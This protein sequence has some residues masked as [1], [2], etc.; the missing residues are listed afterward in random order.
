MTKI[1]NIKNEVLIRVYIVG[2]MIALC[3]LII[4]GQ[5]VKIQFMEGEKWRKQRESTMIEEKTVEAEQGNIF[6]DD[7]SIL[8]TS[9]PFFD[10]RFDPTVASDELFF[11][12]V[13][14]LAH[15]LAR[16][17]NN[18]TEGGWQDYLI[19][20]R[21]A[22]KKYLEIL[23]K[24]SYS[25][26]EK[27]K[28]FPIFN[29][30]RYQGGFIT[31]ERFRRHKPFRPLGNRTLG[32]VRK[33]KKK[34]DKDIKVG[35]EGYFENYLAGESGKRLMYKLSGKDNWMPVDDLTQIEPQKGL[36]IVSTINVNIQ[37]VTHKALYSALKKSKAE[38]GVA[39]VMEV[40]TGAIKAITNLEKDKDKEAWG[41]V[42]NHAIAN[43][44]EPGS[45]YKLA[46]IMALLEDGYVEL[47][48]IVELDSGQHQFYEELMI[49]SGKES[50]K[51]DST[52]V[53]HAFEISS[54]V[55]IAKL[56]DQ[57]YNRNKNANRF[58]KRI[59]SFY[60]HLKTNIELE[61]EPNPVVKEAYN[62]EDLWSGITLPWMSIG[63]A[64]ELTP[65]Q[66]LNFYNSVANNGTMMKPYLIKEI[67]QEGEILQRF[68]PTVV[69]RKIASSSTIKDAQ[70]LLEGVVERGTA[71]KLKSNRYRFAAKTGT[72]QTDYHKLNNRSSDLKHVASF[73][74]YFPAD[75]PIYSCIVVIK[76]PKVGSYYGGDVAG[77]VFRQ[78]ADKCFET[79]SAFYNSM[80][81][82][83][84]N[85]L[86][87]EKLPHN[88]LGY[89]NDFERILSNLDIDFTTRTKN[90]WSVVTSKNDSLK[91]RKRTIPK[92]VVPNVVGM[93]LRDALY[94]LE[95]KG[96]RVKVVGVGKVNKQSIIPG[97]RVRG[98]EIKLFLS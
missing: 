74:G 25:R 57:H 83:T 28:K 38:Y 60:L 92:K 59:K 77:P 2:F 86:A 12:N 5:A 35:L 41:E 55:G 63:Y 1:I 18:R 16:V 31:E 76:D 6:A 20:K 67:K 62:E 30:G 15:C 87:T 23:D 85:R 80:D 7:G 39:I 32:Y 21:N 34:G 11:E 98:Q 70:S 88:N 49:D 66:L 51:T 50:F 69:K 71:K 65:L 81:S 44:Y 64:T 52:T 78:I 97:T 29:Q 94:L 13:D 73:A 61:G 8:V 95:N 79:Q 14:S 45:T 56:V 26:M 9:L 40:K 46:S 54:N 42:Y 43:R 24:I 37:D 4:M 58:I 89:R 3:A 75:N 36:D 19:D 82:K 10:I 48:D 17:N 33:G 91:I 72:S 22:G 96:L 68:P 53:R 93:G 84:I 90:E 27:L 47:E